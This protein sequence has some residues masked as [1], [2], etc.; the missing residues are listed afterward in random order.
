M[1]KI[2]EKKYKNFKTNLIKFTQNQ[3][4]YSLEIQGDIITCFAYF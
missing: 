4:I 2:Q 3:K 1:L